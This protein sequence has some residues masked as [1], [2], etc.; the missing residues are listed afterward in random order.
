MKAIIVDEPGKLALRDVPAPEIGPYEALVK[1]KACGF[2]NSTDTKMIEGHMKG[3]LGRYPIVLGHEGVGEIV[4]LG[5]KV[6][7]LKI[8]DGVTDPVLRLPGNTY[9]IV[10]GQF[11]EYG[12]AQDTK[13]MAAD[14]AP[15]LHPRARLTARIP[16]GMSYEDA[17]VLLTLKEAF[18]ALRNFGV[19]DGMDVLTFGD[20]PIG[21]ALVRFMKLMGA[22]RVVT[23][24]HWDSR[25][26]KIR[27]T[28]GAD[29]VVNEK[30]TDLETALGNRRFDLVIDA[31]GSTTIIRQS[32][33]RLKDNGKVCVFGVLHHDDMDLSIADIR[34]N[35]SLHIL[36]FPVGEH[37]VHDEV[38]GLIET[39]KIDPKDYYSDVLPMARF[40]EGYARVRTREAFKVVFTV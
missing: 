7:N 11:A 36:Q 2:C 29:L 6:R 32:F 22:A 12:I 33:P 19:R 20:G 13:A 8:G 38:C 15:G 34:N 40:D 5:P 28:G 31:V 25:L 24:G 35:T 9:G 14:G 39:G 30:S 4:E 17:A 23:V 27:A 10:L 21:L 16:A 18:S 1:V 3:L 26:A 37:A